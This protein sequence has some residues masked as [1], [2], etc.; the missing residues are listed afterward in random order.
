MM[1][2]Q[3]SMSKQRIIIDSF[4]RLSYAFL[5]R[6]SKNNT[7]KSKA[8]LFKTLIF[9][10][11]ILL[12]AQ[13]LGQIEESCPTKI[14]NKSVKLTVSPIGSTFLCVDH[15]I[16]ISDYHFETKDQINYAFQSFVSDDH[17]T[18]TILSKETILLHLN[19]RNYGDLDFYAWKTYIEN[20]KIKE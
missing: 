7:M 16:D 2:L 1:F 15:L 12:S 14:E 5:F 20:I 11:L 19:L 4:E 18:V 10:F 17:F 6:F 8:T 9:T 3:K 13:L